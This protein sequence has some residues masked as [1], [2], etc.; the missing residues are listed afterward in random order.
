LKEI[1]SFELSTDINSVTLHPSKKS[2]VAGGQDFLMYKY[3]YS[4]GAQQGTFP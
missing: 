1:K 2:F 4:S 3:D